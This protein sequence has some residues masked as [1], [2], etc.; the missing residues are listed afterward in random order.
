MAWQREEKQC[1]NARR[2]LAG[3]SRRGDQPLDSQTPEE[4]RLST[5]FCFQLP[6]HPAESHLHHSVKSPHSS[7]RSTVIYNDIKESIYSLRGFYIKHCGRPKQADHLRSGLRDQPGQHGEILSLLKIQKNELGVVS[8]TLVAQ[9]GVQWHDL[10]SRQPPPPGFK[11][12]SCLSLLSSWDYR[13]AP[14]CLANFVFLVEMGFLHIGQAGFKL[15]TSGDPPALAFQSARITGMSHCA[16]LI[17]FKTSLANRV[18]T[19]LYKNIKISWAQWQVPVIPATQEAEA[20]KCLNPGGGSCRL[21]SVTQAGVQWPDL[22]SLKPPPPGFKQFSCFSLPKMGF[23]HVGQTG[24][25]LLTSSDLPALASQS[26]EITDGV[27]LYHQ[28]GVQWRN[29]SSLHLRLPGSSSSPAS[30]CR[31]AGTTDAHHHTQL[32]FV[33]LVELGFHYV[34]Q[35]V[36]F[37][38]STYPHGFVVSVFEMEPYSMAQVGM[39]WPDIVSLQ[40]LPPGLQ[41]SEDRQGFGY[42]AQPALELL[43]SSDFTR[44]CL[45]KCHDYRHELLHPALALPLY[46]TLLFPKSLW[47]AGNC[48]ALFATSFSLSP[49]LQTFGVSVTQRLECS[50]TIS[51]HCYLCLLGSS[52]SPASASQG[53]WDYRRLLPHLANFCI[54]SR[55]GVSPCRPGWSQTP[56]LKRVN[57]MT[58]TGCSVAYNTLQGQQIHIMIALAWMVAQFFL[59]LS[60]S[61]TL[62]PRLECSGAIL[63][64]HNLYLQ[65]SSNSPVSTSQVAGITVL[66]CRPGWSAVAPSQL[67]AT[68]SSWVQTRFLHVGQAGLEPL[69]SSDPPVS[70]SQSAGITG[71]SHCAWPELQDLY[72][73]GRL[74]WVPHLSSGIRDQPGQHGETSS[75]QK[76]QRLARHRGQAVSHIIREGGPVEHGQWQLT[77]YLSFRKY[78]RMV[79]IVANWNES[80]LKGGIFYPSDS[81]QLLPLGM[82]VTR[83][84]LHVVVVVFE[85]ESHSPTLECPGVISTHC[86]LRLLGSS[87]SPASAS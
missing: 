10:G 65:G 71:V 30:A 66:L 50:G 55:D 3:D 53:I 59:K 35:D 64:H 82:W 42:V 83:T 26:A 20:K 80:S 81:G 24:L 17:E 86:N 67:T 60:E 13:H 46:T 70:A 84:V 9:A 72:H 38:S 36:E 29:H 68:S 62:S 16:W 78:K 39:Q 18:K 54:L 58:T 27:S 15:L 23:Y 7:F 79:E 40:P 75:L 77:L 57:G 28:A 2:N 41:P 45:P 48:P 73:F 22:G 32:I 33:F 19:H 44:L 63:A 47:T 14:P 34:G 69:T 87:Y 76:I 51:A 21:C 5:P 25:E 4:D 56:D 6:I 74:R 85:M 31:V 1:L 37:I 61:L 43:T 11:W 52:D 8:F 12:F 49:Q